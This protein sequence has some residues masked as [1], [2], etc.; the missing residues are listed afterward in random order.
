M[1]KEEIATEKSTYVDEKIDTHVDDIDDG[2]HLEEEDDS[3]IEEVRVT[4]SSTYPIL[5]APAFPSYSCFPI[6][7]LVLL[8]LP[9]QN[10]QVVDT[11]L[12]MEKNPPVRLG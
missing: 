5:P 3:P 6:I 9:C 8:T 10:L 2:E 7:L 11:S 1:D 4:I 12:I